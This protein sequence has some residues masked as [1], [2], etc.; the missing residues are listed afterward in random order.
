MSTTRDFTLGRGR[1][2]FVDL[3]SAFKKELTQKIA[4]AELENTQAKAVYDA[5]KL[6]YDNKKSEKVLRGLE[7]P[8]TIPP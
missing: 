3:H 7:I 5:E 8:L 1:V 6:R 4:S 2:V